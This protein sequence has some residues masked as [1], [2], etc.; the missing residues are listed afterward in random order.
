MAGEGGGGAGLLGTVTQVGRLIDAL[1]GPSPADRAAQVRHRLLQQAAREEPP[2]PG[3]VPVIQRSILNREK[4]H[5]EWIDPTTITESA[6]RRLRLYNPK[7]YE[8]IRRAR[9]LG[10]SYVETRAELTA[11]Q[12]RAREPVPTPRLP[13]FPPITHPRA[14]VYTQPPQRPGGPIFSQQPTPQQP[15]TPTPLDR[16]YEIR[17]FLLLLRQLW[18]LFNPSDPYRGLRPPRPPLAPRPRPPVIAKSP[19]IRPT[20]GGVMPNYSMIPFMGGTPTFNPGASGAGL[21]GGWA[22]VLAQALNVG[23]GIASQLLG[24]GPLQLPTMG[25]G[26][27]GPDFSNVQ[28]SASTCPTPFAV[29]ERAVAM[30]FEARNPISGRLVYFAPRG[31]PILFSGDFAAC[32]RVARVASHAR[33]A[34]GRRRGR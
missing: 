1:V 8:A 17:D 4:P 11:P 33:R 5:V 21:G 28:G 15:T 19:P 26:I 7:V 3:L 34:G 10:T 31:R 13:P 6:A 32:R 22:D 25:S 24:T 12:P 2:S 18:E 29:R 16:A 23:G 27:F 14:P 9:Q 30:P 20:T